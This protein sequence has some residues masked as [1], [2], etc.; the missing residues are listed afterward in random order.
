LDTA[1]F[2]FINGL[3]GKVPFL[4]KLYSGI[5][6]DYFLPIIVV[7]ILVALWFGTRD[8]QRRKKNQRVVLIALIAIGIANAL[9]AITNAFYFRSRPFTVL[10]PNQVHLFFYR[11]TDSSF[12]S[13][14]ATVLFA[15]AITV[16]MTDKRAGI[17]LLAIAVIG[18]FGRVF[19]GIHY[20]SDVL[21]GA[22]YGAFA[23][24]VAYWL[25]KLFNPVLS[26]L[27]NLM[28]TFYLV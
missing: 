10:P 11:P 8:P 17:I 20:P 22:V 14:F 6:N 25:G 15:P 27:L 21:G 9:V 24:L 18:A 23:S 5:A 19:I 1:L 16:F 26:W 4:G 12:P 13:N 28:K 3:A 7:L 2:K